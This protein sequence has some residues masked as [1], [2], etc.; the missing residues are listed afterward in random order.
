[1]KATTAEFR[2]WGIFLRTPS[3]GVFMT[4]TQGSLIPPNH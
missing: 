1:M 3:T 2:A 4:S